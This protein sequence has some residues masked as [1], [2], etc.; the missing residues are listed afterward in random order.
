MKLQKTNKEMTEDLILQETPNQE[1]AQ[2]SPSSQFALL[3]QF[4]PSVER[5]ISFNADISFS[6]VVVTIFENKVEIMSMK[7]KI[8]EKVEEN[9]SENESEIEIEVGERAAILLTTFT[10]YLKSFLK[11]IYFIFL[12][13]KNFMWF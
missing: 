1:L 9:V 6:G 10:T 3:R 11:I 12:L 8:G 4:T 13:V 2:G 5:K 7:S